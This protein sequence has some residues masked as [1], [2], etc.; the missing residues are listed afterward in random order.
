MDR[1]PQTPEEWKEWHRN[2]VENYVWCCAICYKKKLDTEHKRQKYGNT[3]PDPCKCA[4]GTI[5]I[6][7]IPC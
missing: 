5:V 7:R 1:V 3:Y 6:R 4:P 2:H